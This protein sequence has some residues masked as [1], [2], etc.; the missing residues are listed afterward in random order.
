M[1]PS[2]PVAAMLLVLLPAM[3]SA[4]GAPGRVPALPSVAIDDFPPGVRDRLAAA[5][6]HAR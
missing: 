1:T 5:L 6:R 3:W 2:T 4:A